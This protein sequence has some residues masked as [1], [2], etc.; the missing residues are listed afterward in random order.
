MTCNGHNFGQL[1]WKGQTEIALH[2]GTWVC[3]E[4]LELREKGFGK[5]PAIDGFY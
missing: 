1:L 3:D 4:Q 2:V 5:G